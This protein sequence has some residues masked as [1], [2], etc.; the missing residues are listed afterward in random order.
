MNQ[1]SIRP[2]SWQLEPGVGDDAFNGLFLNAERIYLLDRM[3]DGSTILS[4][5]EGQ[6][7]KRV[8]V[9][10][11]VE[12]AG[13]SLLEALH[14]SEADASDPEEPLQ[15]SNRTTR[16]Y[17]SHADVGRIIDDFLSRDGRAVPE[18]IVEATVVATRK[19][20]SLQRDTPV[21]M[22]MPDFTVTAPPKAA[23]PDRRNLRGWLETSDADSVAADGDLPG[24]HGPSASRHRRRRSGWVFALLVVVALGVGFAA[25]RYLPGL[26][27]DAD[28]MASME[29]TDVSGVTPHDDGVPVHLLSDSAAV[30]SGPD[31]VA[32]AG[33][34]DTSAVAVPDSVAAPQALVAEPVEGSLA[35]DEAADLKY[36]NEHS[37]WRR[38]SLKSDRYKALF[39]LF[40]AGNIK[41]IAE[42]D[43]FAKEGVA[44]NRDAIRV[45]DML[46]S[47]YRTPTQRSNERELRKFVK[48]GEINLPRLYDTLSRYRDARPNKSPRPKR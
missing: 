27:P 18:T 34:A 15:L 17:M 40:A 39:D 47:A 29:S 16:R 7:E 8:R 21:M 41:D 46:W 10:P 6:V 12:M 5:V 28:P 23:T 13:G 20:E 14:S 2:K 44:T 32:V 11:G 36:L 22:P 48:G 35:T 33:M 24:G 4:L 37:T 43:Y 26:I 19:G 38:S 9:A 3:A 25:V 42:A 31:T 1:S 45:A 30:A